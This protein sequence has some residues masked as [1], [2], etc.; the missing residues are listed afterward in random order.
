MVDS[1]IKLI[2]FQAND[3]FLEPSAGSVVFTTKFHKI[4]NVVFVR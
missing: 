3:R 4:L 2:P 1:I